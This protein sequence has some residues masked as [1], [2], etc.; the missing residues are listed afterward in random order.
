MREGAPIPAEQLRDG[1]LME[2]D[3]LVG[4][5]ELDLAKRVA[6]ARALADARHTSTVS[7]CSPVDRAG[8]YHAAIVDHY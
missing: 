4:E 7:H 6:R 1:V 3:M 5:Q 2:I 8:I